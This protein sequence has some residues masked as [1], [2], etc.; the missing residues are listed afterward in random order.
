MA[1]NKQ[2]V[3]DMARG[4][5]G[6]FLIVVAAGSLALAF[7]FFVTNGLVVMQLDFTGQEDIF[8]WVFMVVSIGASALALILAVLMNE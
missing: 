4:R 8:G 2:S 1:K 5:I 6:L 7:K 3:G